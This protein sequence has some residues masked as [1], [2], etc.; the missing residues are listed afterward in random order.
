MAES[1][2]GNERKIVLENRCS[3]ERYEQIVS[4]LS[5]QDFH[6]LN[7]SYWHAELPW[8]VPTREVS[9]NLIVIV[10]E[11]R[12]EAETGR[13]KAVLSPGDCM[14]VPEFVAHSYGFARGIRSAKTFVLH[15][16]CESPQGDNPFRRLTSPFFPLRHWPAKEEA[17]LRIIA[18]RSRN[19]DLAFSLAEDL[20]RNIFVELTEEGLC[21]ESPVSFRDSRIEAALR[22]MRENLSGTLSIRDIAATVSLRE[23]RFRNLFFQN[24]GMSPAAWLHRARLLYARRLLA[25][26]CGT[27]NETARQCGFNSVSYF[28]SSFRK[29]FHIT[30]EE[31]RKRFRP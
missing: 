8:E 9:D 10:H 24:C 5:A 28:C 17:L 14:M 29:F 13:K 26:S 18:L 30:P 25:R 15:A 1:L 23:V 6:V 20:V 4:F 31:Y 12:L 19:S 11:G 7:A 2:Y 21:P 3:P 22:F 16:L 27:L